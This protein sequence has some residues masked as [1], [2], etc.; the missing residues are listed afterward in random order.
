MD[1]KA[2]VGEAEIKQDED[3]D[4]RLHLVTPTIIPR[5]Q[6]PLR[7]QEGQHH[8]DWAVQIATPEWAAGLQTNDIVD[9][10]HLSDNQWTLSM[11]R[12]TLDS[13]DLMIHPIG[14]SHDYD[15]IVSRYSH[16]LA[17]RRTHASTISPHASFL[18]LPE[19]VERLGGTAMLDSPALGSW[20]CCGTSDFRACTTLRL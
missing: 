16:R 18:S 3:D 11:V 7:M 9:F 13:R 4:D 15:M 6:L 5:P 2:T 20:T 8:G 12:G 1:E 19:V 14:F 17:P 10:C